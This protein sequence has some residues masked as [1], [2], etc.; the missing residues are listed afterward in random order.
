M[1]AWSEFL[2][3]LFRH[4][5]Y[6]G[7][8]YTVSSRCIGF[9]LYRRHMLS[10][11]Y[12]N[13][14]DVFLCMAVW[15]SE[16]LGSIFLLPLVA[17]GGWRG[18]ILGLRIP[19]HGQPISQPRSFCSSWFPPPHMQGSSLGVKSRSCECSQHGW[20]WW[21][22]VRR[23]VAAKLFHRILVSDAWS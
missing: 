15:L 1:K 7:R 21:I 9:N 19:Y 23:N 16:G 2:S 22:F 12:K 5:I 18:G 10:R 3:R 6:L 11:P 17:Y 4:M 13:L 14:V 8:V 20:T